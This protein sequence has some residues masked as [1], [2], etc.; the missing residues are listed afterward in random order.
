MFRNQNE[1]RSHNIKTEKNSFEKWKCPIFGNKL[2]KSK[3]YSG[4]NK[5]QIEF[6][7]CNNHLVQNLLFSILLSKNI[8][9]K[10]YRILPVVLYG[11]ET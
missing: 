8:K 9:L 2:N 7:E 4:R 1:G 10:V 3:F 11:C 6:M 5:V